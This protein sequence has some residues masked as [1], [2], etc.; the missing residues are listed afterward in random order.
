MNRRNFLRTGSVASLAL[1]ATSSLSDIKNLSSG[2]L[3]LIEIT[4]DTL[5]QKM[6]TGQQ[7]SVSI[8][9]LYLK[10]IAEIDR[11]GPKLNAIIELNP[12]AFA[13]A[14]KMDRER[15]AGKVRGPLHG[16]PVLIK[17][18][19]DTGDSMMTTAGSLALLGHRAK[20][21][22]FIVQQL[23]N[24]GAVILGKTNLSEWSN[25]RASY[26]TSGWSSRGGLTRNACILDRNASGSS[27]GS[28]VAVA[29]NL[30][31]VAIGTETDGSIISP[32]SHNGVVGIKPTVGLLSRTGI[33]PISKTQD[34]AG[35]IARTVKDAVILLGALA[36]IDEADPVTKESKPQ[37]D[38]CGF[39]N[40][41]GLSNKRIGI[42]KSHLEGR[43]DVVALYKQAIELFKKKGA[44]I[45]EV[46]LLQGFY[47]ID[48]PENTLLEYEF[49]EGLN[50][51]LSQTDARVKSLEDVIHFN[52]EHA[53]QVMPYFK[54]ETMESSQKLGGSDSKEYIDALK[55]RETVR[56]FIDHLIK[57]ENLDAICG[58][59]CGLPGA[60]D[61]V[62]GDY[63][64][65]FYFCSPAA[66]AGYPH[67]TV[68]MGKVHELPAGLSFMAGA[69]KEP[70]LISIAYGYEQASLERESPKFIKT[71]LSQ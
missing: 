58:I 60:I 52:N 47:K 4:I 59:S 13:I 6:E 15:K 55:K 1:S 22:A 65:G 61:L 30:C 48:Y 3:D 41:T 62:N 18:N 34:T 27:S 2:D 42:E 53:S 39:L 9:R 54:Q 20:K 28:S 23:R 69:Y 8:T 25:S 43:P 21:D 10:R 14:D 66:V 33:I 7:T 68:P 35:P 49:K 38:Y 45:I 12:D 36:G 71:S 51:Y 24:A 56:Q 57:E 26:S 44:T 31:A 17:D 46:D 67:I 40:A 19:I 37:K 63:D 32:A 70:E 50:R 64:T 29:A 11:H 16:I 5:R